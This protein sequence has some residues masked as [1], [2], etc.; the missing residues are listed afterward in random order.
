ML[1]SCELIPLEVY[2]NMHMGVTY[3]LVLAYVHVL[4]I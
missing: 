4:T 2:E 1:H 3:M